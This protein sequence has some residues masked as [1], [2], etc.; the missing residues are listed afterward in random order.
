MRRCSF[1]TTIRPGA[2][3]CR[4]SFERRLLSV[5][6]D[7]RQWLAGIAWKLTPDPIFEEPLPTGEFWEYV[8]ADRLLTARQKGAAEWDRESLAH[9]FSDTNPSEFVV[10][11]DDTNP[12]DREAENIGPRPA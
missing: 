6:P 12:P 8:Q 5:A 9:H 1:T 10:D 7:A 4:A 2:P 11:F 3:S